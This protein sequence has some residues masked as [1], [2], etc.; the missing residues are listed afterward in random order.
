MVKERT[1]L[2]K[3]LDTVEPID[4]ALLFVSLYSLEFISVICI[5]S[6]LSRE[7]APRAQQIDHTELSQ[8]P[9]Y[10]GTP[11]LSQ[12]GECRRARNSRFLSLLKTLPDTLS[13][14][15]V[16][17][18]LPQHEIFSLQGGSRWGNGSNNEPNREN[19]ESALTL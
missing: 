8:L 2:R 15:F 13:L 18:S 17:V 12:L 9:E 11:V 6:I 10:P 4:C 7:E 16:Q 5:S 14:G 19:V 3:S 1:S